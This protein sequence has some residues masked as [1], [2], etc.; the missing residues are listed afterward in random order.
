MISRF[1]YYTG[2]I[3]AGYTFGSGE[4]VVTGGRYDNLLKSFGKS[5]AFHRICGR[6]RSADGGSSET[7]YLYS[8]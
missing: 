2:I 7:K 8:F 1:D 4:A 5:G 3:F 6:D